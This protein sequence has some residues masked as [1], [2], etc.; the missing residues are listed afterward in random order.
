MRG[1]ANQKDH[2]KNCETKVQY[3]T[4]FE[5]IVKAAKKT[6]EWVE[7][8]TSYPCGNHWHIGHVEKSLRNKYVKNYKSYCDYC[9]TPMRPFH[10][11]KHILKPGHI[12]AV[13]RKEP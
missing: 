9:Q 2:M 4:E 10:Y 11:P 13:K 6:R 5:S 3:D 12:N 1:I 7:E 8:M